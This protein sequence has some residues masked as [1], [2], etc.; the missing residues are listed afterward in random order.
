MHTLARAGAA[1]LLMAIPEFALAAPKPLTP[2][3]PEAYGFIPVPQASVK[4]DK[5]HVYKAIFDARQAAAK[6]AE[7]AP[8]LMF[9]GAELNTLSASGVPLSNIDFV[10]IF[11]TT[12]A[13]SAV[14][15]N[16]HYRAKFG[17]DNPNLKVLSEMKKAHVRVYVCAQQLVADNVPFDSLSPDVTLATD[18]LVVLMTFENAGYAL[19]SY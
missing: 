10:I 6:P 3:I 9:A 19:L 8:A 1:L 11:H 2:V 15:D 13:D 16:A 4:P 7:L 17:V 14:W 5:S 12:D 18:G